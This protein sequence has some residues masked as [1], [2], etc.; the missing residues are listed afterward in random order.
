MSTYFTTF[1]KMTYDINKNEDSVTCLDIIKRFKVRDI[2][3][4]NAYIYHTYDVKEGEKP[5]MVAMKAYGRVDLEWLILLVNFIFDPYYE[6]PMTTD[7]F[8]AFIKKKYG[9]IENATQTVHHFERILQQ[10]SILIDG[11]VVPERSLIVDADSYALLADYE[12]RLVYNY[13]YEY[14]L[15]ESR[16]NI[17]L[18]DVQYIRQIELELEKI[19]S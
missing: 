18:L 3:R 4:E 5:F 6:W 13:D 11:T 16:R 1:K 2:I 14:D 9:S 19:F 12:R 17:K 7:E 8:T 15:N 10:K